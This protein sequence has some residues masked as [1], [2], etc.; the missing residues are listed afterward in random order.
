[1]SIRLQTVFSWE[2][3]AKKSFHSFAP[4]PR[5]KGEMASKSGRRQKVKKAKKQRQIIA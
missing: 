5:A 3:L 4:C 1:M 2:D